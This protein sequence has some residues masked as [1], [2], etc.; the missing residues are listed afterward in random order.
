VSRTFF[1]FLILAV[2]AP[3]SVSHRSAGSGLLTWDELRELYAQAHPG[4]AA[5]AKLNRLL[6]TPFVSN[7]AGAHPLKP[8]VAGR[9]RVLRVAQ[10]NIERGLEFEAVEAALGNSR[11]L[12]SLMETRDPKVS[13][14]D[15]QRAA[16]QADALREA[17]VVVLN[18]VDW[19]VNRTMFRNVAAELAGALHMN[20]A[21]GVEFVEVDPITMGLERDVVVQ[22]VRDSWHPA[23]GDAGGQR[24][25][26]E[27]LDWLQRVMTPEPA[28]YRGLHGSAILSRYPL[29]RVRLIPFRYQGHDWY[30]DERARS[31]E[32]EKAK[33]TAGMMVFREQM[34]RQVRRGGR[35]MLLADVTDRQLP[36]GRVTIVATHLEDMTAPSGRRKQLEEVLAQ[37]RTIRNP[38]VLA[39]DMNTSTHDETPMTVA[40]L[41]RQHFGSAR[42][43]AEEGVTEGLKYG[44]PLGWMF[45]ASFGVVGTAR[46]LDDPT[47][48]S[49]PLLG[50]NHEHRFFKELEEFRFADG[51]AFDF[52]GNRE[53]TSNG[54]AGLLA[55]S[56][57]RGEKGFV[58][59]D[60]L[61]RTMGPIGQYKLDWIFV[62]P[63]GVMK[64][65]DDGQPWRFAPENGRTL[66]ALNHA[67]PGKI[68]DHNPIFVD[69]PF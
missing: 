20:Y 13:S 64:P 26:E 7:A 40:R 22:E 61:G 33:R 48:V 47:E 12:V 42:W 51:R 24:N 8:V 37:I 14:E 5:E 10:W 57:E 18:E 39:G 68:S 23:A 19:G 35:M 66:K 34:I 25:Q 29:S 38:V 50:E 17:D 16:E 1:L 44:T 53:R 46:K 31:S 3:A 9:G 11:K 15:T 62:S 45:E 21:Y 32:I 55:D 49:I 69:L 56:N 28:R 6:R 41:M 67:I 4:G 60:E 2:A 65:R 36:A 54:R 63:P 30:A 52:R 43:W 58:P 59:T 27:M